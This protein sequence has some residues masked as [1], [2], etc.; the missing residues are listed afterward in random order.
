MYSSLSSSRQNRERGSKNH[1]RGVIAVIVGVCLT[2]L[3]G[4]VAF[5]IDAG[6]LLDARRQV[7]TAA[8]AAAMAGAVDLFNGSTNNGTPSINLARSNAL[9]NAAANGYSNDGSQSIVTINIPP[10]SG[11]FAGKNG[12]VEAIVQY[13]QKRGFSQI[14]G[15]GDIPV[16]ARAVAAGTMAPAQASLVVLDPNKKR[17]LF[18]HKGGLN[19]TVDG[20]IIV[21]SNH[22]QAISIG[23]GSRA[24]APHF[25][26]AGTLDKK[27][28]ANLFGEIFTRSPVTNDPL[29]GLP[30]PGKGT[31]LK[32]DDFKSSVNGQDVFNLVPGTYKGP[33][34]FDHDDLV[35]MLPGIYYIDGGGLKV[36]NTASIIGAGVMIYNDPK[37]DKKDKDKEGITIDTRGVVSIS[38]PVSGTYAGISIFQDR[39]AKARI[40][41]KHDTHL[42][43]SGTIYAANAQVRFQQTDAEINGG[44]LD[45]TD[46]DVGPGDNSPDPDAGAAGSDL[47]DAGGFAGQIIS[48]T[49]YLDKKSNVHITG[50]GITVQQ[51]TLGVAE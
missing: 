22:K 15:T 3:I 14:F 7:Q 1:P 44:D 12:Y 10:T 23:K 21:N 47:A 24:V 4:V 46:D 45:D 26:I 48:R 38:P 30:V 11:T 19:L 18:L 33:L 36:K 27:E 28:R 5:A 25:S 50:Q 31:A 17:S 41:F 39:L 2:A 8:D 29:A 43:I 6:R 32:A 42:D 49:L 16:R 9:A 35:N 40:R 51:P 34:K 37:D 13:N 20:N